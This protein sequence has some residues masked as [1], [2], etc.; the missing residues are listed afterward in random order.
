MKKLTFKGFSRLTIRINSGAYR[1]DLNGIQPD[2]IDVLRLM[3]GSNLESNTSGF[4]DFHLSVK[5]TSPV[6][7]LFR[8]QCVI[9]VEGVTPFNPISTKHIVPSLEWA[10]NWAVAA[11]EHTKLSIHSS[12]VVKNNKAILFPASSGSGKSTLATYL[13]AK[14]WQMF[15][16]E[17]A[18][19]DTQSLNITPLYRP[20]SLKNESINV[21][22]RLCPSIILSKSALS[23][24]K[25]DIAHAK[26]Y[27]TEE[28]NTFEPTSPDFVTFLR[29]SPLKQT[30]ITELTQSE[31]FAMLIRNAFNYNIL[32]K[33]G[34]DTLTRVVTN[35]RGYY[36][37]YSDM[38]DLNDFLSELVEQ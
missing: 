33:L 13:G 20:S 21:I 3:Y 8:K 11:F 32:G 24:H 22:Q 16:D 4:C 10:M 37:E 12:V 2:V 15:S 7:R 14:G 19:I 23:T 5:T 17:M 9:D 36:I 35:T 30:T 27:S 29:Y 18:L 26:L 28:F 1:F 25:G 38:H 6:R 34:F 31:T